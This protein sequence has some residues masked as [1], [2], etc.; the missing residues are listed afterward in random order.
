MSINQAN[1][2]G[3]V[4]DG[5]SVA[6]DSREIDA[7][8]VYED[9]DQIVAEVIAMQSG[10]AAGV[11]GGGSAGTDVEAAN[12][13]SL[14]QKTVLT[15]TDLEVTMTD[16]AAAGS[17]GSAPLFTFPA[18][19]ILILGA[20][21]T[22]SLTAGSGGLADTAAVVAAIGTV[23]TAVDNATLTSTEADII[24]STAAT[25]TDGANAAVDMQSTAV[26]VKD[27]TTTA[28]VARLNLAVPDADS[29]ASDTLTVSGTVTITWINLGDN[30]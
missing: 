28:G 17:H 27:G 30:A 20:I 4:W 7:A 16:A 19:N 5:T 29:T 25:L 22:L 13:A 18:G 23:A 15:L 10:I 2:P 26:A 11:T 1:F 8:P 6:R 14:V 3:S 9:W 21:G 12:T 24:P